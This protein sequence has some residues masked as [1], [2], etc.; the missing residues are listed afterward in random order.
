M[1]NLATNTGKRRAMTL[2]GS[3]QAAYKAGQERDWTATAPGWREQH[4]V[5]ERHWQP[6]SA[7]LVRLA[8]VQPGHRVL[9]V[10]TGIGEPAL[11]VA[12]LVGPSGRVVGTDLSPAM[13]GIAAERAREQGI[14]NVIFQVCD[15]DTGERPVGP[16]DAALCRWP[17]VFFADLPAA[18]ARIR[19]AL[20]PGSWLTVSVVGAADRYPL[21][22]TVV[23]AICNALQL[24]SPT[25]EPPGQP[26]FFSLADPP[27]LRAALSDAGFADVNVQSFQI[28]YEFDSGEQL[29]DW[30][31]A[32]SAP[33]NTLLAARPGHRAQA[34]QAVADAAEQYRHADGTIRFPPC[35]HF[36]ATGRNRGGK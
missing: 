9:D 12:A 11:A 32:I 2:T 10:A 14:T 1:T 7:E 30:Q 27:A 35:E 20:T 8:C 26:G 19:R 18:L 6:V 16:F 13:I 4:Q 17:L 21:V 22:T 25:P 34:R 15:A 3:G 33:V 29:A 31:F 24:P 36:Y 5:T 28:V 23:A